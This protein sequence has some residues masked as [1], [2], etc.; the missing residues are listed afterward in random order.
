MF[1]YYTLFYVIYKFY[2]WL[3]LVWADPNGNGTALGTTIFTSLF[4]ILNLITIF[5][6]LIPDYY[7]YVWCANIWTLLSNERIFHPSLIYPKK[8]FVIFLVY[9]KKNWNKNKT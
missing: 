4:P 8:I 6:D 2:I 9:G 7:Y 1:F 5:P 3:D